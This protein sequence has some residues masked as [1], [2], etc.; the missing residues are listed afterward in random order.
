MEPSVFL[1]INNP[2]LKIYLYDK[3]SFDTQGI[4][5][6]V[7]NYDVVLLPFYSVARLTHMPAIDIA[8]NMLSMSEMADIQIR[9]YCQF[10]ADNLRGWFY[11]ENPAQTPGN[12]EMQV[13]LFDVFS[14]YFEINPDTNFGKTPDNRKD[15][16]VMFPYFCCGPNTRIQLRKEFHIIT[17][18]YTVSVD[19]TKGVLETSR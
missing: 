10:L 7:A 13:D 2:D 5:D 17:Q 4:D 18:H 15:W 6:I 1:R 19:D 3:K 16:W 14:E 12:K 8:I 11:S 9:A